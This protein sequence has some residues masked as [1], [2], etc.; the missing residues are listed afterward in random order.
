MKLEEFL[1]GPAGGL[2]DGNQDRSE[3]GKRICIRR[4]IS[5]FHFPEKLYM[6]ERQKVLS[7]IQRALDA[8]G[9]DA[10]EYPLAGMDSNERQVLLDRGMIPKKSLRNLNGISLF[11]IGDGHISLL[12]NALDHICLNAAGH[13]DSFSGSWKD[14]T[15]IDDKLSQS[16]RYAYDNQFG[17][18]TGSIFNTG[19]GLAAEAM[20]FLPGL[21]ANGRIRDLA[22]AVE[23]QGF[24]IRSLTGN[25]S[26][27]SA[28]YEIKSTQTIGVQEEKYMQ[29]FDS[30]LS[31]INDI[32]NQYWEKMFKGSEITIRDQIWRALGTLKYAR[33]IDEQEAMKLAGLIKA[34]VKEKMIP[35]KNGLLFHQIFSLVSNNQVAY[36]THK[37]MDDAQSINA[38]RAALLRDAVKE[39]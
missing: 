33:Q 17:Y 1:A 19:T 7:E 2:T 11:L 6:Q 18:L 31:D 23:R 28:F 36:T 13:A 37:E 9:L 30:L 10:E 38:W 15:Q 16:I 12:S 8:A 5:G 24:S 21:T 27:N 32:E 34:G 4:N 20:L 29:R 26:W 25:D 35:D 39:L 22:R 14:L 3:F